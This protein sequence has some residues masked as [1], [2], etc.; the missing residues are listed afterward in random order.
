MQ[1]L[2]VSKKPKNKDCYEQLA[3]TIQSLAMDPCDEERQVYCKANSFFKDGIQLI[4]F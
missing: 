2:T 4:V 1:K 3:E